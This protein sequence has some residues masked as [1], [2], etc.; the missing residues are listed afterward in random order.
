MTVRLPIP[1]QDDG[2][3]G[4]ILNG[5]LAVSHNPDGSLI[6][7]AVNTALPT[8]IPTT[9][10]GSGAATSSNF[11]RG[12]GTWATPTSGTVTGVTATDTTITVSGTPSAPTIGVNGIPESKVTNLTTDLA[13]KANS[14]SLATVATSGSYADLIN[15]PTLSV[16]AISGAYSDLTNK[17]IVVTIDTTA[18]DIQPLGSQAAGSTNK[19]ADAGH[20]H[21]MPRLDQINLPTAAVAFN[22]QKITGIANG[23]VATDG[24]AYGQIPTVGAG[25]SNFAAGNDSRITGAIQSGTAAGGDLSGTLPSPTVARVNGVTISGTAASGK[26]IIASSASAASW[27][28][29]AVLDTTD[30]PSPLGSASPGSGTNGA[31]P[32]DHVH[33]MP[34]L[35]QLSDQDVT[36]LA[37]GTI[38]TWNAT[39]GKFKQIVPTLS[40]VSLPLWQTL[41]SGVTTLPRL[42]QDDSGSYGST[43]SSG[44]EHFTYFRADKSMTIGHI[45]FQTGSTAAATST[46]AAVGLYTVAAGTLTLVAS[47]ANMTTFSGSYTQQSCALTATYAIVI[48]TIYVI[49]LLQV[50][51]TPASMLGAW[52]NGAYMNSAPLLAGTKAAQSTLASSTSSLSN[53][54]FPIYYELIA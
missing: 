2:T 49:G 20:V 16:V 53:Q 47:C 45:Q 51:A 39:A 13:A 34:A 48:G 18:S 29:T 7:S 19:A 26:T 6:S 54:Q 42:H 5:F 32:S 3:W 46:Y 12:D 9:K 4:D 23:A 43:P 22:A 36:G 31:A 35:S 24:A 25:G 41:S 50:A 38:P 37:D 28:A 8:P 40:A 52:F 30:T 14:S 17:P 1:G 33:A 10:L 27:A 21:T 11:L 44:T 15:K